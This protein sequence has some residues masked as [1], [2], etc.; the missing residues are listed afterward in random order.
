MNRHA[1]RVHGLKNALD[2]SPFVNSDVPVMKTEYW[3]SL[4]PSPRTVE[5]VAGEWKRRQIEGKREKSLAATRSSYS[6]GFH[7]RPKL[8]AFRGIPE[9]S[10]G[11][12]GEAGKPGVTASVNKSRDEAR[13]HK[14]PGAGALRTT[15]QDMGMD[16]H[17]KASARTKGA[18]TLSDSAPDSDGLTAQNTGRNSEA[19]GAVEPAEGNWRDNRPEPILVPQDAMPGEL[20]IEVRKTSNAF[21]LSGDSRSGERLPDT[22]I[23]PTPDDVA[24]PSPAL[25]S[26]TSNRQAEINFGPPGVR[27][28]AA[29]GQQMHLEGV[30]AGQMR[31]HP[32]FEKGRPE[33]PKA[34]S[35]TSLLQEAG[36]S[37]TLW[38][39]NGASGVRRPAGSQAP[40]PAPGQVPLQSR[41]HDGQAKPN[42]SGLPSW[43]SEV[44]A[45]DAQPAMLRKY[46]ELQWPDSPNLGSPKHDRSRSTS[47]DVSE[48]SSPVSSFM[49]LPSYSPVGSRS[50]SHRKL[51]G[52]LVG[53]S[54]E[55]HPLASIAQRPDRQPKSPKREHQL[56][57]NAS[58]VPSVEHFAGS[59]AADFPAH[60]QLPSPQLP[61]PMGLTDGYKAAVEGRQQQQQ[62]QQGAG[63]R[64]GGLAH[65]D[66]NAM[67]S[68]AQYYYAIATEKR[69]SEG[70]QSLSLAGS[71]LSGSRDGVLAGRSH[72]SQGRDLLDNYAAVNLQ[73]KLGS[74]GGHV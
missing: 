32:L 40:K 30:D 47:L 57:I 21:V 74:I 38:P 28:P 13:Q 42:V 26:P 43:S 72:E 33:T 7:I 62:Q 63:S 41:T 65:Q 34:G 67:S 29:S 17:S 39:S 23:L 48:H 64:D 61:A 10:H 54:Q 15:D 45:A 49:G 66:D 50:G 4:V 19:I 3:Q 73:D 31:S 70:L 1:S 60:R 18:A 2:A 12:S 37:T 5:R 22:V 68:L 6:C 27:R 11:S 59:Y 44:R 53:N 46:S 56:Q 36:Y 35:G 8:I 71:S 58:E 16:G 24:G 14:T 25:S 51:H 9:E 55:E 52:S 20:P 69:L